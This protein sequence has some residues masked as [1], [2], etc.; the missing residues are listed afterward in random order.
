MHGLIYEMD[1][2]NINQFT[3]VEEPTSSIL[4]H[5]VILRPFSERGCV[6]TVGIF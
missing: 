5:K 4:H 1:I 2:L 6:R 3:Q